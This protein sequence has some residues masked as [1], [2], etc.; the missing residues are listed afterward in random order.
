MRTP[1]LNLRTPE[2]ANIENLTNLW[3]RMGATRRDLGKGI[4]LNVSDAWPHRR[5]LDWSVRPDEAQ[6]RALCSAVRQD[7][8]AV[9]PVWFADDSPLPARLRRVGFRVGFELTAM[10][11]PR[12]STHAGDSADMA[13]IDVATESQANEWTRIASSSFGYTVSPQVVR[14]LIDL[15]G[16][17]MFVAT[18]DGES[19]GTALLFEDADAVGVHM[20]GVLPTHRRLGLARRIMNELLRR[21]G[22]AQADD[23][24]LQASKA[25]EPL[26]R[27]L[28]F[29]RQFSI[30]HFAADSAD[31]R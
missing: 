14:S 13:L 24:V 1:E 15:P 9:V 8:A 26:Y 16:L 2:Q 23:V 29:E 10:R 21:A 20:L 31:N 4:H 6:V 19:V 5:W 30:A 12:S 22:E 7:P 18:R 17:E 3:R 11:R 28:G 25:A 27:S